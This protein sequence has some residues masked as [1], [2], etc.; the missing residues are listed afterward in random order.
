LVFGDLLK[1]ARRVELFQAAHQRTIFA[2]DPLEKILGDRFT[3]AELP[4]H[5][6]EIDAGDKTDLS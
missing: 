6:R 1:K 5:V 4:S 3:V 2:F